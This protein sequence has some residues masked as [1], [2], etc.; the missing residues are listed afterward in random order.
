[1][2]EPSDNLCQRFYV[3]FGTSVSPE[4]RDAVNNVVD[5][6]QNWGLYKVAVRPNQADLVIFVRTGRASRSYNG[7]HVQTGRTDPNAPSPSA[8]GGAGRDGIAAGPDEDM[9]WV[10]WRSTDGKLNGPIWQQNLKDGLDT[11]TLVLF[12]NFKDAVTARLAEQAKK[13]APSN[14]TP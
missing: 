8:T 10:Y 6:L 12:Q 2:T 3:V 14:S 5:A 1:L 9:F 13:K 11:P 7:V 4:D